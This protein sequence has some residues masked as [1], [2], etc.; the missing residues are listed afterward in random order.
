[1]VT[2][3]G[4]SP[5][6][7]SCRS[8][9]FSRWTIDSNFVTFTSLWTCAAADPSAPRT[10]RSPCGTE[11]LSSSILTLSFLLGVATI[12][13]VVPTVRAAC[14]LPIP[15]PRTGARGRTLPRPLTGA[16]VVSRPSA[17]LKGS[18]S[19]ETPAVI[20][21]EDEPH[22]A[23]V[24]QTSLIARRAAPHKRPEK[25]LPSMRPAPTSRVL[26]SRITTPQRGSVGAQ[27]RRP[28]TTTR[29]SPPATPGPRHAVV[30]IFLKTSE[31]L[32]RGLKPLKPRH[33]TAATN[34]RTGMAEVVILLRQKDIQTMTRLPTRSPVTAPAE[35]SPK[36]T[37]AERIVAKTPP[38]DGATPASPTQ[39]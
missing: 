20:T 38:G 14:R 1:M 4:N 39:R 9:S 30:K 8:S 34:T 32:T 12:A 24:T 15:T 17:P 18:L 25:A 5:T 31:T 37:P 27:A 33:T 13:S 35:K 19:V 3:G 7:I 28:K 23:L 22:T 6:A 36:S 2:S 16:R 29:V 26:N 11:G 10:S 21:T